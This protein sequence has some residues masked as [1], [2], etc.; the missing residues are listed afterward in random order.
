MSSK[1]LQRM[2]KL[3]RCEPKLVLQEGIRILH[4]YSQ[5][6]ARFYREIIYVCRHKHVGPGHQGRSAKLW[7]QAA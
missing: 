1:K 6:A 2:E 4:V 7:A 3:L 5:F